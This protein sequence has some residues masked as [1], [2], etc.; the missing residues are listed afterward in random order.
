MKFYILPKK[1]GFGA[2]PSPQSLKCKGMVEIPGDLLPVYVEN[3]GFVDLEIEG[4]TVVSVT[5]DVEAF[6][7]WKASQTE[8]TPTDTD[9]GVVTWAELDAAYNEGR[10]SAYDF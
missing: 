7:A 1:D 9:S 4:E 5:P 2:Y 3:S 10:D 8:Q 6:E